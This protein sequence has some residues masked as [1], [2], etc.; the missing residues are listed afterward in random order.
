[1]H[2]LALPKP[3]FSSE[4]G[5]Q[6]LLAHYELAYLIKKKDLISAGLQT[7][8]CDSSGV[9]G[10][11]R[12]TAIS[13]SSGLSGTCGWVGGGRGY[14]GF[15][16][17]Y[18]LFFFS[19]DQFISFWCASPCFALRHAPIS[20]SGMYCVVLERNTL[21]VSYMPLMFCAV[22]SFP[23]WQTLVF[24]KSNCLPFFSRSILYAHPPTRGCVWWDGGGEEGSR[25]LGW[26]VLVAGCI[27]PMRTVY[28]WFPG[29]P[30][31]APAEKTPPPPT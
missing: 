20:T 23:P 10:A 8:S 5:P 30:E 3:V 29:V 16:L 31:T 27:A 9:S 14:G 24:T 25:V 22:C 19:L 26:C 15:V 4:L 2:T 17:F 21:S 12:R 18:Y 7:A 28:G 6:R 11:G 13:N 1:M